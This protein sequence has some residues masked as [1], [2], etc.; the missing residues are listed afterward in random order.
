MP[1]ESSHLRNWD[2]EYVVDICLVP[3]LKSHADEEGILW[4]MLVKRKLLKIVF[5]EIV[6]LN[7]ESSNRWDGLSVVQMLPAN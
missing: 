6:R 2:G 1:F 4:L 3:V 5:L 7:H